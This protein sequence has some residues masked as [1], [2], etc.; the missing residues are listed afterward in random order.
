MIGEKSIGNEKPIAITAQKEAETPLS[1]GKI[2]APSHVQGQH[3][4]TGAATH[5]EHLSILPSSGSIVIVIT[6]I[7]HCWAQNFGRT[8]MFHVRQWLPKRHDEL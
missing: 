8:V 2:R 1:D 5:P 7:G 6:G 4:A 3:S